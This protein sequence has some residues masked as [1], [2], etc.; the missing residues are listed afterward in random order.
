MTPWNSY[1]TFNF[2][3][4]HR[5]VIVIVSIIESFIYSKVLELKNRNSLYQNSANKT[6]KYTA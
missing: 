4:Y 5:H 3:A 1:T 6:K 2:K